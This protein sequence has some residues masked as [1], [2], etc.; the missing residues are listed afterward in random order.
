MTYNKDISEKRI[1]LYI[2]LS[3]RRALDD[4]VAFSINELAKWQ[5]IKPDRHKGKTNDKY[6]QCLSQLNTLGYYV[7]CPDFEKI[8]TLDNYYSISLN[9][10]QFDIIDRF[11]II[12]FDEIEKIINFKQKINDTSVTHRIGSDQIFLLLSYIR[13]NTYHRNKKNETIESNP[14][15]C[16]RMYEK[17][18][19]DIGLS[20]RM[21]SKAVKIL[22][23]LGIIK[24]QDL[25]RYHDVE[26][27]TWHT[28]CK[29]FADVRRFRKDAKG[30][31]KLDE[32][33]NVDS[34][35][36]SQIKL[37]N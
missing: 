14:E 20:S 3:C 9:I 35:M 1:S 7:R 18:Q 2:Y 19:S 31:V 12:Y 26:N 13:M 8:S 24:Y 32:T 34:E 11:G 33:Y 17:I 21:I 4:T 37:L 10:E 30:N 5:H 6:K 29:V 27:K 16:Y 23:L 28:R 22:S 25:L 15:C 36:E